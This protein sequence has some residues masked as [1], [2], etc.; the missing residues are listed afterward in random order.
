MLNKN[1]SLYFLSTGSVMFKS[2]QVEIPHIRGIPVWCCPD[3]AIMSLFLMSTRG[4][5]EEE[6]II[7]S[8][9][10]CVMMG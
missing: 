4:C 10:L 9:S 7:L 3:F 8:K 1:Q 5:L 6:K 2:W